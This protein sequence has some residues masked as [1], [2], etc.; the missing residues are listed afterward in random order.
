MIDR[1]GVGVG[2]EFYRGYSGGIGILKSAF[3][4]SDRFWGTV[5]KL[6]LFGYYWLNY[7]VVIESS[8]L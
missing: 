5:K 6:E 2:G 8:T 7:I 4:S 3:C 1:D